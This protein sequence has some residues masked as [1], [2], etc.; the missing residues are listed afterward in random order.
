MSSAESFATAVVTSDLGW[1]EVKTKP[2]ELAAAMSGASSLA[3]DIF[4]S[5]DG[6]A[7]ALARAVTDLSRRA[8]YAVRRKLKVRMSPILARTMAELALIEIIHPKCRAC[9]GA[10]VIILDDLKIECATC[11]GVQMH[12]YSD[13][14]RARLCGITK[15]EWHQPVKSY[16]GERAYSV[17]AGI[18]R[19]NDCAAA[20]ASARLG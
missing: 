5:Q 8:S 16:S 20:D 18:A 1:S 6:D 9:H 7:A 15:S 17:F 13:D 12:R 14:E 11:G 19:A 10:G 4:R 2:V 3:S